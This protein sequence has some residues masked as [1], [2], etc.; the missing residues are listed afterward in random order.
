MALRIFTNFNSNILNLFI[1]LL[2]NRLIEESVFAKNVCR[3]S[4]KNAEINSES[5]LL[6]PKTEKKTHFNS[7]LAL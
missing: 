6:L 4:L 2:Q 7:M 1:A 3:V 5:A